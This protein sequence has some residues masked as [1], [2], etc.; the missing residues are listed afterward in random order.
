MVATL[1]SAV[2]IHK[3]H[4]P[5]TV[6]EKYFAMYP[7]LNAIPLPANRR[8]PVG[9]PKEAWYA[10]GEMR[11]YTCLHRATKPPCPSVNVLWDLSNTCRC[12][13][14]GCDICGL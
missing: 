5:H 4:L 10:S 12:V 1:H 8:V 7:D 3:P 9:L 13:C 6:P 14:C 11:E 2:G